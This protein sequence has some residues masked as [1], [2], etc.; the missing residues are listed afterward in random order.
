MPKCKSPRGPLVVSGVVFHTKK[1]LGEHVARMRDADRINQR[2]MGD[3]F[4][5]HER[6]AEKLNGR[7]VSKFRLNHARDGFEI[8]FHDGSADSVSFR[9]LVKNAWQTQ[10]RSTAQKEIVISKNKR[11]SLVE[12]FKK[13]ARYEVRGQIRVF[14]AHRASAKPE[15]L[16]GGKWHVGHDYDTALRFEE[17]LENFFKDKPSALRVRVERVAG[18]KHNVRWCDRDLAAAW[19]VYHEQHAVLR[20]E[21]RTANLSGNKGFA[22]KV[23]WAR[24]RVC[25]KSK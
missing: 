15:F 23:S 1:S 11:Q 14:R 24:K 10:G 4:K 7:V 22:A 12:D 8:V 19:R 17:L 21:T 25:T 9:K 20:M 16:D 13:A 6:Y 5:F 18:G 3:L 2:F